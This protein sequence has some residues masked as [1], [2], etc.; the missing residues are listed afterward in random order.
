MDRKNIRLFKELMDEGLSLPIITTSIFK[1]NIK[2]SEKHARLAIVRFFEQVAMNVNADNVQDYRTYIYERYLEN[3]M[4]NKKYRNHYSILL[5]AASNSIEKYS[6]EETLIILFTSPNSLFGLLSYDKNNYDKIVQSSLNPFIN[7]LDL[8]SVKRETIKDINHFWFKHLAKDLTNEQYILVYQYY[9]SDSNVKENLVMGLIDENINPKLTSKL[10][11]QELFAPNEKLNSIDHKI[12]FSEYISVYMDDKRTEKI[13]LVFALLKYMNDFVIEKEF[14]YNNFD[15]NRA[16]IIKIQ[17][18]LPDLILSES[19]HSVNNFW[20]VFN[21][22]YEDSVDKKE[23][24]WGGMAVSYETPE[25]KIKPFI[26]AV[27]MT[28]NLEIN[29]M[30]III[31]KVNSVLENDKMYGHHMM[32]SINSHDRTNIDSR[33]AEFYDQFAALYERSV[34]KAENERTKNKIKTL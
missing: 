12:S 4:F 3:I 31:E 20:N 8:S 21:F 14:L 28:E 6:K 7:K 18:A 10:D 13:S 30:P 22:F 25:D 29:S 23:D 15:R 2:H 34:L 16:M 17:E 9:N 27:R 26:K 33:T 1:P 24:S 11:Y 5:A 19:K 32:N